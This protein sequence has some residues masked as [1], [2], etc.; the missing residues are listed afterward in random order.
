MICRQTLFAAG[1][2]TLLAGC[3]ATAAKNAL[4]GLSS[5]PGSQDS[6]EG[7]TLAPAL[8]IPDEQGNMLDSRAVGDKVVIVD[9]WASWC[10]PCQHSIPF[11][12]RVHQRWRNK[13]LVVVGVNVDDNRAAMLEYVAV[14][15]LPF[16]MVWDGDKTLSQRF[17]VFQLPTSFLFDRKGRLRKTRFGFD[18]EEARQIEDEIRLLLGEL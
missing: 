8:G 16:S 12:R 9:F 14:H 3:N 18:P 10:A 6:E 1:L 7:G 5:P 2:V 13:G 15:P 11:Y 4:A 17:G